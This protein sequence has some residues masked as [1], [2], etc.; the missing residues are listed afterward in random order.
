MTTDEENFYMDNINLAY[1]L[2]WKYHKKFRGY[3]DIEELKSIC[4]LGLAKAV[5]TFNK[6]LGFNFSTYAYRVIQNEV[7]IVNKSNQKW[8]KNIS[9]STEIYD[10]ENILLEDMVDNDFDIDEKVNTSI[11]IQKLYNE[12]DRM[13]PR[14]KKL[15]YYKLQGM[16]M[17]EIGEK[18]NLSQS[19]ISIDYQKILCILRRKFNVQDIDFNKS[20]VKFN[21]YMDLD[22]D[23][24]KNLIDNI[25][26]E[27]N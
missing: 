24:M 12:L 25:R 19:Q 10:T 20:V 17:C 9:L 8:N 5:K 1:K 21:N 3:I 6:E 14:Y 27:Q 7:L 22:M 16:T 23:Y 2:A 11:Y 4:L 15:I 18:L 13:R 26:E